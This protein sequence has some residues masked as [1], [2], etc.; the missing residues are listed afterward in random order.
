MIKKDIE[1]DYAE[2]EGVDKVVFKG[3]VTLKRLD[4]GEYFDMQRA[5]VDMSAVGKNKTV[6]MD[7]VR[8][9][10]VGFLKS[11]VDNRLMKITHFM[12]TEHN[13]IKSKEA[14]YPLTEDSLN[15]LPMTVGV[16]T[17]LAAFEKL[18]EVEEKKNSS[19]GTK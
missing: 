17:L 1:I 3:T 16:E 12:D 6:K 15:V 7:P 11:V 4:T 10:I 18:N 13:E 5:S 14:P 8:A 2:G 19:S 9:Q